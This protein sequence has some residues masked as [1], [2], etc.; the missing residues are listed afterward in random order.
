MCPVPEDHTFAP[1]NGLRETLAG[2]FAARAR[3][4]LASDFALID[5]RDR[6][7]GRLRVHGPE[8]A[9]LE[10]GNLLASI[11][12]TGTQRYAMLAGGARILSA[13]TTGSSGAMRIRRADHVYEA[14]VSLL[15]NTAEARLPREGRSARVNGGLTNRR[16]E[17][18][19]DGD[20]E[21]SLPVAVFL[22]YRLVALRR[23]AYRVGAR[24]G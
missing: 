19:F 21:G 18:N 20:D 6:E 23:G 17:I 15:R 5:R 1:W 13:E 22:L 16:Y 14:T 9:E 24:G 7:V 3:G 11:E 4:L 12:H 8:G 2:S 10:A